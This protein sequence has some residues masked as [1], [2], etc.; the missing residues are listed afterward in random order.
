M[1]QLLHGSSV[2]IPK[3]EKVISKAQVENFVQQTNYPVV[4]KPIYGSGSMDVFIAKNQQD[5][6]TFLKKIEI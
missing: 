5:I 3:F 1:K 6:D 4:L 2:N